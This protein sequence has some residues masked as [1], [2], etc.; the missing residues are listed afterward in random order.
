MSNQPN[1]SLSPFEHRVAEGLTLLSD[2][3]Q[4]ILA[5]TPDDYRS[6]L[7]V[8]VLEVHA[9]EEKS[10]YGRGLYF[11]RALGIINAGT[12]LDVITFKQMEVL[13]A[14][15]RAIKPR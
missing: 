5:A 8:A 4:A 2:E 11:G 1:D 9:E 13:M 10:D 12:V 6:A 14:A 7:A 3:V 15:L